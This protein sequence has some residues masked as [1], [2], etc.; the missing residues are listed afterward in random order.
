MNT[1]VLWAD[2]DCD[3]FLAPLG[4]ILR[5]QDNLSLTTALTFRE[6]L[7]ILETSHG[8][9]NHTRIHSVLLDI[10]LPYD[11]EGRGALMSDLGIKLADIAGSSGVRVIAFLT[12]VRRDEVADKF[13]DLQ[14]SHPDIEFG[15]F[16]KTDLLARNELKSLIELLASSNHIS[17][18]DGQK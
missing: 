8:A 6:A 1:N 5:K 4:R 3:R 7:K 18:E 14:K 12:V 17:N 13:V 9:D 2:D 11:R 10:I 16:D 15:Y